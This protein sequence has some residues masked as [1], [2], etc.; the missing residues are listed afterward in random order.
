MWNFK[1]FSKQE[2]YVIQLAARVQTCLL[3]LR[4]VQVNNNNNSRYH[5]DK[6]RLVCG[7]C[8]YK[9]QRAGARGIDQKFA[10]KKCAVM[11]TFYSKKCDCYHV[12]VVKKRVLLTY[13]YSSPSGKTRY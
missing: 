7:F 3:H 10:W 9:S 1:K 5:I 8:V 6:M 11:I 2:H 12:L 13:F 4:R